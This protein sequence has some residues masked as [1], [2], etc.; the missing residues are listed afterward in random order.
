MSL[1]SDVADLGFSVSVAYR[2]D[3]HSVYRVS[4]FGV[5]TYVREDDEAAWKSLAD[6]AAQQERVAQFDANE[7]G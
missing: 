7:S 6:P 4:G 3:D 5:E 2:T 1:I